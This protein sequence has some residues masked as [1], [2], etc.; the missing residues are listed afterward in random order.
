MMISE[1]LWI[2]NCHA[3]SVLGVLSPDVD[4]M[5]SPVR[6]IVLLGWAYMCFFFAHKIQ[7]SPYISTQHKTLFIVACLIAGPFV[8]LALVVKRALRLSLETGTSFAE[9]LSQSISDW[10]SGL[11][12]LSFLPG[13]AK[14]KIVIM[15][16]SGRNIREIYGQRNNKQKRSV[17]DLTESI[18]STA[19]QNRASDILIDPRSESEYTIRFRIDGSLT[20]HQTVSSE[21]ARAVVNSLKAISNMDIA[22]RRRPQDGAFLAH[23]GAMNVSFR[24]ASAGV[25]NGE[26][27]SIRVLNQNASTHTLDDVGLTQKQTQIIRKITRK[28]AGMIL[29]CGPTGSGKTSTLYAMLNEMDRFTRNVV[30]IEDPIEAVLTDASQ[31]EVNAKADITFA[32]ALR[33]ILRQD[34]D[35]ICVGEIRDEETAEIALRAAQTG[36]LV[37]ATIHCDSN[38]DAILRLLDLGVSSALLAAGLQLIVSQRLI[39]CLCDNCKEPANLTTT[40]IKNLTLKNIDHRGIQVSGECEKCHKTGY[41]G[42]TAIADVTVVTPEFREKIAKNKNIVHELKKTVAKEGTSNLKKQGLKKAVSGLTTL[43][44]IKRVLG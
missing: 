21:S 28:P 12:S 32:N 8:F 27:L 2:V 3:G 42:R 15:D 34:P 37:F 31:I 29:V 18:I 11:V 16:S 25:I 30:T 44:E 9:S 40:Q 35:V 1:M 24:M 6:L 14:T 19:V 41:Y 43:S 13:R 26:K 5:V 10:F 33:S 23:I 38:S 22:E 36:H 39:R 20:T 4:L 7:F 17:L